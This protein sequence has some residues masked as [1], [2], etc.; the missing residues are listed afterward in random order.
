MTVNAAWAPS[1]Q[2]VEIVGDAWPPAGGSQPPFAKQI[3]NPAECKKLGMLWHGNFC[4]PC[5][6]DLYYDADAA[7]CMPREWDQ[8]VA[9][10]IQYHPAHVTCCYGMSCGCGACCNTADVSQAQSCQ[11]AVKGLPQAVVTLLA[12][13]AL[14]SVI[15][16][17]S[18]CAVYLNTGTHQSAHAWQQPNGSCACAC[19]CCCCRSC[20]SAV[21]QARQG[22]QGG[23]ALAASGLQLRHS[24]P[25]RPAR[26]PG[27]ARCG[28]ALVVCFTVLHHI[29]FLQ[30][31]DG[32][33][34]GVCSSCC[35]HCILHL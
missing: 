15:P 20:G 17:C 28:G 25:S 6:F 9:A 12:L 27:A 11:Y 10:Y 13:S 24:W 26:P 21:W 35:S 18:C 23:T 4:S 14:L 5:P 29:A 19:A 32:V 7:L 16:T 30:M 34:Q 33:L 22:P 2:A 31:H 8:L 1:S 3:S